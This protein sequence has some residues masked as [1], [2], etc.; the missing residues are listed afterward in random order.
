MHTST[1]FNSQFPG[2]VCNCLGTVGAPGRAVKRSQEAVSKGLDFPAAIARQM[3]PYDSVMLAADLLP[4]L[5][6]QLT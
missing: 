6:T 5:I 1:D 2:A 3:S 4:F